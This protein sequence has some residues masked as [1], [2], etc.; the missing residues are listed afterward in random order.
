MD[1]VRQE[2]KGLDLQ[3]HLV[4][5]VQLCP[6]YESSLVHQGQMSQEVQPYSWDP[7]QSSIITLGA[8]TLLGGALLIAGASALGAVLAFA[9]MLQ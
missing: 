6:Q 5:R 9:L 2:G 3:A 7:L 1:M 4:V 8:D